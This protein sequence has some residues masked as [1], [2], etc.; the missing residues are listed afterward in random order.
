MKMQTAKKHKCFNEIKQI[1]QDMEIV[2]NKDRISKKKKVKQELEKFSKSN[3]FS[4][5]PP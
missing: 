1:I 5:K 3:K 2:F 4:G